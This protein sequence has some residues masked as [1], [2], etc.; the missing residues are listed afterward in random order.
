MKRQRQDK[1]ILSYLTKTFDNIPNDPKGEKGKDIR[2][3]VFTSILLLL[4]LFLT[5]SEAVKVILRKRIGEEEISY[6]RLSLTVIIYVSFGIILLNN[7][8]GLAQDPIVDFITPGELS[9]TL[10]GVFYLMLPAVM[11][12]LVIHNKL[13]ARKKS[14]PKMYPGKSRLFG[15][16]ERKFGMRS[17]VRN[18]FDPLLFLMI[19]VLTGLFINPLLG[20]PLVICSVSYWIVFGVEFTLDIEYERLDAIAAYD[21]ANVVIPVYKKD[22]SSIQDKW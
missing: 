7:A 21:S 4:C 17:V 10:T 2:F 18:L 14:L 22:I 13:Q 9:Y 19:G 11:I 8:A 1:L 15:S 20:L 5:G 12:F 6:I 16:I 3:L